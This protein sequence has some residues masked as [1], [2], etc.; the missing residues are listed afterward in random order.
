MYGGCRIDFLA[1]PEVDTI[2]NLDVYLKVSDVDSLMIKLKKE[3]IEFIPE[4]D[5]ILAQNKDIFK[6]K[7]KLYKI[8]ENLVHC[9]I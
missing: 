3:I 5:Y 9:H 7:G 6:F 1:C 8:N 2:N 4:K